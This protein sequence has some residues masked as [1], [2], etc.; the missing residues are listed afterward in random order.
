MDVNSILMNEKPTLKLNVQK[1]A[2]LNPLRIPEHVAIVM[3]GNRRWAKRQGLPP[4]A[5]HWKGADVLTEIVRAASELNIQVLTVYAFSTENWKRTSMEIKTLMRLFKTYLA[6]Q[7]KSMVEEGVRLNVIGDLSRFP[8]DVLH[9][10]EETIDATQDGKKLD[11]VLALNYGGR[12][13]LRRAV[14]KIVDDCLSHKLAKEE[15]TE[16]VIASYLDTAQWKDPDLLIRTS[17]ENRISNFLLWQISYTEVLITDV[18]WPDF[19]KQD[20]LRAVLEYQKRE[21]RVGK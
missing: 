4:M 13:E 3:D 12:D 5:G 10:L 21:M 2:K 15:I 9:V 6:R 1:D 11:L 16:E 14:K 7:R 17:G 8:K 20:L 18:L 19:S